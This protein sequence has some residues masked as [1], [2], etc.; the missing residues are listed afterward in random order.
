[1]VVQ[2]KTDRPVPFEI[3][4]ATREALVAGLSLRRRRHYDWL[5]PSRSL[6]GEHITTRQYARLVDH[7]VGAPFTGQLDAFEA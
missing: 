1:M 4:D 3:T 5:F 7:V 6:A 2:Q